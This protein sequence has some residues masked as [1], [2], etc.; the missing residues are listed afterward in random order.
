MYSAFKNEILNLRVKI[1]E[2]VTTNSAKKHRTNSVILIIFEAA[3]ETKI[4]SHAV[5]K[6][7]TKV[8][9][10]R[11]ASFFN[12]ETQNTSSLESGGG[13]HRAHQDVLK[14]RKPQYCLFRESKYFLITLK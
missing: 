14:N 3:T 8:S 10:Q 5:S 12:Q 7:A 1:R 11:S 9:K 2:S 13:G 4:R 6:V